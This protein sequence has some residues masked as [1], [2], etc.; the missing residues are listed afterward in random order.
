MFKARR[1]NLTIRPDF[2]N[3]KAKMNLAGGATLPSASFIS[4]P[5]LSARN[6]L[7]VKV[8]LPPRS[9]PLFV[10][11]E[12]IRNALFASEIHPNTDA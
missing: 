5:W 7:K 10:G 2:E 4:Q 12:N 8:N 3:Q 9:L 11:F 6:F 1:P